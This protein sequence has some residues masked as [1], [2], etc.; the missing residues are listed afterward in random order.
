[1]KKETKGRRLLTVVE[2]AKE[3]GVSKPTILRWVKRGRLS[4]V[5]KEKIVVR[6]TVLIPRATIKDAFYVVCRW[7][8]ER[9]KA[10]KNPE[11]ALFCCVYHKN[12]YGKRRRRKALKAR[13]QISR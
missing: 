4:A 6:R 12:L 11:K 8:H 5:T 7:C 10:K 3:L 13:K 1:M 9:F 2:A